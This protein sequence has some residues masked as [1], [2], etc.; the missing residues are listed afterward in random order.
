MWHLCSRLRL[1]PQPTWSYLESIWKKDELLSR[2][3][4]KKNHINVVFTDKAPGVFASGNTNSCA[5]PAV[6]ERAVK[7]GFANSSVHKSRHLWWV[8]IQFPVELEEVYWKCSFTCIDFIE[9]ILTGAFLHWN[10]YRKWNK[11]RTGLFIAAAVCFWLDASWMTFWLLSK[12]TRYPLLSYFISCLSRSYQFISAPQ[13]QTKQNDFP[14][15][16]QQKCVEH[17][18]PLC[19]CELRFICRSQSVFVT[20]YFLPKNHEAAW[21]RFIVTSLSTFIQTGSRPLCFWAFCQK[22]SLRF[23][24]ILSAC[25]QFALDSATLTSQLSAGLLMTTH[26]HRVWATLDLG[27]SVS[28]ETFTL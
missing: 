12:N 23:I 19:W 14:T 15:S 5:A 13:N 2:Y 18:T 28:A 4:L 7:S 8:R 16:G 9:Y 3:D 24:L 6:N 21:I 17:R 22:Y 10:L 20:S 26:K 11:A 25:D 27:G 1:C